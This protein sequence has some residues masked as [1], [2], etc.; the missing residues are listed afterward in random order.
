MLPV[1]LLQLVSAAPALAFSGSRRPARASLQALAALVAALPAG[2]PVLVGDAPGIDQRAA[3]LLPHARV[4][5]ASA[6]GSGP[7]SFAARSIACVRACAAA[8]G[9]WCA[10]PARPAPAALRPSARSSA[11]FAG[12]GSGTW[13]SLAFAIGSALPAIVYLPAGVPAPADWDL[14]ALSD[15]WHLFQPPIQHSF[16]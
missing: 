2:I 6:Y 3:A 9:L 10:F 7:G 12:F 13:A 16:I 14:V 15:G 1:S 4:L 11:C 8:T 5:H